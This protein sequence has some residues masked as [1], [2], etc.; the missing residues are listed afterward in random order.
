MFYILDCIF[1][2]VQ[3]VPDKFGGA[4]L[5]IIFNWISFKFLVSQE[6]RDDSE[7]IQYKLYCIMELEFASYSA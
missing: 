3:L 6:Q 1:D 2:I 4:T 5:K 7:K